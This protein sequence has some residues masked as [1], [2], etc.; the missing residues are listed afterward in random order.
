M[1]GKTIHRKDCGARRAYM[2][3]TLKIRGRRGICYNDRYPNLV[4]N[5][6]TL[7]SVR[8]LTKEFQNGAA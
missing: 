3:Q 4:K 2:A 8:R 1:R 5:G 6:G 7:V